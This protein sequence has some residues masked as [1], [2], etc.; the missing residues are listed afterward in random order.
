[1][2]APA[3]REMLDEIGSLGGVT[4]SRMSG[5]GATCFALF[6]HDND[7]DQGAA[8]IAASHPQWWT[9]ATRLR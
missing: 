1:M 2:A 9:L 7:R 6:D 8:L 3:I 5:S 4:L